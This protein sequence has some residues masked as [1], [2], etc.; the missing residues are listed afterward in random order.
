MNAIAYLNPAQSTPYHQQL[1]E[2]NATVQQA[3]A[4][5]S[6]FDGID[7]EQLQPLA[8]GAVPFSLSSEQT[9]YSEG[10]SADSVFLLR[11]G[12]IETFR[13]NPNG[14]RKVFQSFGAGELMVDA[15]LF[16]RPARYPTQAES[17]GRSD[18]WR[19]PRRE[20][21]ALCQTQPQLS[22]RLLGQLSE[23]LYR[24]VNRIDQLTLN[25]AAQRLVVYLLQLY[26]EQN[27]TQLSLPVS[28]TVLSQQ[29]NIAPETLSRLLQKFRQQGV[30][31]G[32]RRQLELCDIDGLCDLVAL[33][34]HNRHSQLKLPVWHSASVGAALI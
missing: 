16:N 23:Q 20:L 25:S 27:S 10:T 32:K 12:R 24:A 8:S 14:E 31:S 4:R 5:L 11:S 19:L 33:S 30:L 34:R 7:P 2:L 1:S 18:G 28:Y 22:M 9:L 21:L 3:F 6:L 13:W 26:R 29:L 17:V 15:G